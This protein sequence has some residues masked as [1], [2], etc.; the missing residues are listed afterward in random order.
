M[1]NILKKKT[2]KLNEE[3]KPPKVKKPDKGNDTS[4][5]DLRKIK[6]SKWI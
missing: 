5:N 1:F 3:V 2:I 4:S 6:K